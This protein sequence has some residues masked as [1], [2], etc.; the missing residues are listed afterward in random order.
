MVRINGHNPSFYHIVARLIQIAKRGG[1]GG[2]GG[3][4]KLRA[5]LP[6]LLSVLIRAVKMA[7]RGRQDQRQDRGKGY[8]SQA[9]ESSQPLIISRIFR[10][11]VRVIVSSGL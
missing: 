7:L 1:G 8:A 6:S 4:G 9:R 2:V 5:S 11:A 10:R 3:G